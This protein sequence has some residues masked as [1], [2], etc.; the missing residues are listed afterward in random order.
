L[1]EDR[2]IFTIYRVDT[3]GTTWVVLGLLAD[4]PR[5]GY[6]IKQIVDRSTRFFWAASYGQI[7]PEL[8][9]LEAEGLVDGQS[10]PTGKRPRRVFSLT[11]TGRE[12]L[13]VWLRGTETRMEMRDESLLRIFFADALPREEAL[14]LLRGRAMGFGAALAELRAIDERPGEDPLFVDLTLRYG[15]DYC[16]WVVSWCDQQ[17]RR[18]RRSA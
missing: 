13:L 18:L 9:R 4:R 1:Q 14:G 17:E 7:Y 6:E 10:A 11:E 16:E 12:A 8:R 2:Y 15:L 3:N 5:T